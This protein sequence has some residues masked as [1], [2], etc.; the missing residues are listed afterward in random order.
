MPLCNES[1]TG[2]HCLFPV[3]SC[4]YHSD[5]THSSPGRQKLIS[6]A[7]S[8]DPCFSGERWGLFFWI[9]DS[10]NPCSGISLKRDRALLGMRS[11][12][13]AVKKNIRFSLNITLREISKTIPLPSQTECRNSKR[14]NKSLCKLNL[15]CKGERTLIVLDS[16]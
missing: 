8:Q 12:Y 6:I 15:I 2:H 3:P 5:K 7:C 13:W 4:W 16:S 1:T 14:F 10:N 11:G 9:P